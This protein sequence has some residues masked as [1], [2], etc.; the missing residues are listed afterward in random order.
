MAIENIEQQQQQQIL[1]QNKKIVG[2]EIGNE[3]S[4]FLCCMQHVTTKPMH[5]VNGGIEFE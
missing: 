2:K 4:R 5:F 1:K 3:R